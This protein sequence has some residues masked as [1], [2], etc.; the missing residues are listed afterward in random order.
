LELFPAFAIS[1]VFAIATT[2]DAAAIWARGCGE[3]IL[4][5]YFGILK[6]KPSVS[7][8]AEQSMIGEQL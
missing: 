7:E 8:L 1:L 4:H 3:E 6:T 2:E 5:G